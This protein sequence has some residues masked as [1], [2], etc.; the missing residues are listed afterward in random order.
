MKTKLLIYSA[1]ALGVWY[2]FMKKPSE[3][4]KVDAKPQSE[5]LTPMVA[6]AA[7]PP[8]QSQYGN[9]PVTGATANFRLDG[10]KGTVLT[11]MK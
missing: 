6:V 4:K 7:S 8:P 2:V 11:A 5:V 1:L 9:M 3:K 10:Y